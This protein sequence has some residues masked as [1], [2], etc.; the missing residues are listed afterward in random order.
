MKGS[1]EYYGFKPDLVCFCKAL[2][3][4]FPI[5]ALTGTESLK[6]DAAKIFYTGS[7]WYQAVPMAAAIACLNELKRINAPFVMLENGKKLF[8][9]IQEIGKS[10]GYSVKVT[11][12]Y[13]MP[14]VRVTN[15]PSN[16]LH[17]DWCAECTKRGA[18]FASHHNWFMSTAH[19]EPVIQKTLEI[20]EDA[21][22]ALKKKYGEEF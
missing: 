7:Y 3:N 1:N 6:L 20:T 10:Y 14:T 11:G 19:D 4:G 5:S 12:E 21:F 13:S 22:K 9:G 2:A 18:F 17:Q 8:T 15:D 16:M